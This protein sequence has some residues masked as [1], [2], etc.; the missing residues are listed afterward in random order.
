M[1]YIVVILIVLLV[2]TNIFW[3]YNALDKGV[4]SDHSLSAQVQND[5]TIETLL[6]I[7]NLLFLG[8]D[9][10]SVS[11]KLESELGED[12]IKRKSSAIFV[13]SVIL[14]FDDG[15]LNSVKLLNDVTTDEYDRLEK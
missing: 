15:L 13:G 5:K 8:Q 4:T 9:Y 1:K 7:N 2:V 10:E 3:L 12:L 6:L 11:T 14:I